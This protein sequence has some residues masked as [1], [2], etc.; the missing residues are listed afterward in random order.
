[1]NAGVYLNEEMEGSVDGKLFRLSSLLLVVD[2]VLNDD[3]EARLQ[4][5]ANYIRV[6]CGR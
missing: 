1:M 2:A 5:M 3:S 6:R 4:R